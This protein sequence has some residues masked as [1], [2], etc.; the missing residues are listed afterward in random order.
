MNLTKFL[1]DRGADVKAV[2]VNGR[3]MAH[4]A[5]MNGIFLKIVNANTRKTFFDFDFDSIT[6]IQAALNYSNWFMIM[7]PESM[8]MTILR[9]QRFT[10]QFVLVVVWY[11]APNKYKLF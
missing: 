2:D 9:A 4:L 5:A 3:T 7:M 11:L 6:L 1:I 10:M 8:W